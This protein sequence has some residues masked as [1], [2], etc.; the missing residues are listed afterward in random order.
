MEN[1]KISLFEKEYG[2]KFP[3][4]KSLSSE[5]CNHI[6][7]EIIMKHLITDAVLNWL[8]IN[9]SH[10]GSIFT[11]EKLSFA[12]MLNELNIFADT[13][14]YVN[15]YKFD[16]IDKMALSDFNKYLEDIWFAGADDIDIFDKSLSWFL[17]IRHDGQLYK[18]IR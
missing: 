13:E 6:S 4:F 18:F 17:S 16:D 15:W 14:I 3:S 1:F 5:E 10:C 11:H 9:Q 2:R 12:K 7:K 8:V